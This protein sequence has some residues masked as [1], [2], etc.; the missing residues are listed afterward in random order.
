MVRLV[1]GPEGA[2]NSSFA[3]YGKNGRELEF[4]QSDW[5]YAW[6]ARR[7][8]WVSCACGATDGTV[9]CPHKSVS[10]LLSEAFAPL[11]E[12]IPAM[13]R[14]LAALAGALGAPLAP[15]Q[16]TSEEREQIAG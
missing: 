4:V 11:A 2:P 10:Q 5:D 3:V 15:T 7:F 9:S 6:L 8:G 13:Q 14:D 16:T 12:R 1:Q